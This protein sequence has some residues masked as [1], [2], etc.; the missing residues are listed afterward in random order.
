MQK[1]FYKGLLVNF[2]VP[3]IVNCQLL[4]KINNLQINVFLILPYIN[5][6]HKHQVCLRAVI[7]AGVIFRS[8][9]HQA[10]VRLPAVQRRKTQ[11][12][13]FRTENFGITHR[14][15]LKR[16]QRR[17][18]AAAVWLQQLKFV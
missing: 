12:R 7:H 13:I 17:R 15:A 6:R 2:F 4:G 16:K 11:M 18:V 1:F 14:S 9:P 8:A 5:F 10:L 3:V